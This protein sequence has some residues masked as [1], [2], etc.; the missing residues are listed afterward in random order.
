[1]MSIKKWSMHSKICHWAKE[2]H[3]SAQGNVLKAKGITKVFSKIHT[4]I[5]FKSLSNLWFT[6][7]FA[8]NNWWIT[9]SICLSFTNKKC[10]QLCTKCRRFFH[11]KYIFMCCYS[12][13]IRFLSPLCFKSS[14]FHGKI[15]W[16]N[17]MEFLPHFLPLA[18]SSKRGNKQY[19][20]VNQYL[21]GMV[22]FSSQVLASMPALSVL[23]AKMLEHPF[24]SSQSGESGLGTGASALHA[25]GLK[26]CQHRRKR[27]V[28]KCPKVW[29]SSQCLF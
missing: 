12:A 16:S 2:K 13:W 11:T 15:L 23:L 8:K 18:S 7:K 27:L 22:C 4:K 21:L 25:E 9:Y 24:A 3:R 6:S 20:T 29:Y 10:S 28:L 26:W 14:Y 19:A 1:M 17:V 5:I